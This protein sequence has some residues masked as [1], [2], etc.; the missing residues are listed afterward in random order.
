M[1][2]YQREN[3]SVFLARAASLHVN[4]GRL[5][6]LG[7]LVLKETLET[8]RPLAV[9]EADRQAGN[10]EMSVEDLLP[11]AEAWLSEAGYVILDATQLNWRSGSEVNSLG[12]LCLEQQR[13]LLED[14]Y[15]PQRWF[16]WLD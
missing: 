6:W 5:P 13:D 15:S 16:F 1:K 4:H 12:P 10:A 8:A 11:S 14:G 9:D 7:L 3:L 2:D